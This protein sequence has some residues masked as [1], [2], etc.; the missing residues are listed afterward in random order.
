MCSSNAGDTNPISCA[1]YK[2]QG[3]CSFIYSLNSGKAKINFL[4]FKKKVKKLQKQ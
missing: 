4:N 3:F 2:A 1:A